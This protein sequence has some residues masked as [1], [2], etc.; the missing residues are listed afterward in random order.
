M[1]WWLTIRNHFLQSIELY[2]R[3]INS[4]FG[5]ILLFHVYSVYIVKYIYIYTNTKK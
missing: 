3:I 5:L 4:T 1:D 2:Q